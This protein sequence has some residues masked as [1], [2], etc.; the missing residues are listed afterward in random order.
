MSETEKQTIPANTTPDFID[1]AEM[2]RR[3]PVSRRTLHNWRTSGKIPS[4]KIG[5]R[6]LFCW[7]NV[8]AAL[9]RLER[10]VE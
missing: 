9:R 3:L 6:I 8:S 4:I 10:G 2:L 5:R 1:A 7:D